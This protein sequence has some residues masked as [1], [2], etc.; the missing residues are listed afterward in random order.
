M[1]LELLTATRFEKVMGSG[2]T[3]PCLLVCENEAGEEVEVVAKLRGHPQMMPGGL[4]AE[5][6]ASLLALDLDLPVQTPYR[7]EIG[8]AFA[9][10]VPDAA[11]RSVI[12]KSEGLNFGCAKWAPGYTI[13]PRD[14]TPS[15]EM[16]QGVMEIF[17]FDGLIQNPD[18]RQ[19]N[20]NCAFLGS[21][22]LIFDHESAFSHFMDILPVAPWKAGGLGFLKDHIFFQA[23][24]GGN[25]ALDRLQG[26]LEA[27]D[28]ARIAAYVD[29]VPSEWN[30]QATTGEK[31]KTYLTE[32]IANFPQI[33]FQLE[34]LL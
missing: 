1:M 31:I 4:L 13:W 21:S 20:P 27:I 6:V 19:T 14:K 8:Q 22:L 29:A 30:G 26:A 12:Q 3:Q 11:L 2:L 28:E 16:K 10:T 23:L 15:R 17:A 34:A 18:R 33:R 9:A 7:I 25:L 5:A 24:R 32:C